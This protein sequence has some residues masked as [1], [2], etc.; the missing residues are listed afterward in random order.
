MP[1]SKGLMLIEAVAILLSIGIVV[2][3]IFGPPSNGWV[4]KNNSVRNPPEGHSCVAGCVVLNGKQM[5]DSSGHGV[6][7]Q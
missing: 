5:I 6:P 2:A 7:C 1:R 3:A 4:S